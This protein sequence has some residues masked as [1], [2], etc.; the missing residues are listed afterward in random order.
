MIWFDPADLDQL[1]ARSRP[2]PEELAAKT[3][4]TDIQDKLNAG[5]SIL[6]DPKLSPEDR[7]YWERLMEAF[8]RKLES[9]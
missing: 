5:R 8:Q 3:P 1:I 9:T 6:D 2:D 4:K 7:A